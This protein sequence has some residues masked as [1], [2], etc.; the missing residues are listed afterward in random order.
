MSS[1]LITP[2][3]VAF[4][5]ENGYVAI[6]R[7]I[8]DEEVE[9]YKQL[10]D[11]FLSGRIQTGRLRGDLGRKGQRV[12][13]D[14]ENVTQISWPSYCVPVLVD[15]PL[16]RR[17]VEI[18]R[19]ALGDDMI[20]DF[21]ML[22][23]KAPFTNTP[24]AWHQDAAYWPDQPDTRAISVWVALDEATIDNGCLWFVPGSHKAQIP[25]Q[26]IGNAVTTEPPDAVPCPLKPGGATLHLGHTLHYSRGNTTASHRRAV[27]VNTRPKAMVEYERSVGWDHGLKMMTEADA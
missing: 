4:L 8:S 24:T 19:I 17:A 23:D 27:I 18:S 20:F 5:K 26:R 1:P 22:I 6:E 21:D 2:E 15:A 11:R 3:Q 16:H 13:E 14:V 25:L 7:L 9:R 10:Y 12:R